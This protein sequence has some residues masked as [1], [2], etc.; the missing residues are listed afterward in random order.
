M[1]R[2]HARALARAAPHG[3]RP[4]HVRNRRQPRGGNARR[5]E[6][7]AHLDRTFMLS[8][9]A[10]AV[11]G[12]LLTGFTGAGTRGSAPLSVPHDCGCA[13]RRNVAGGSARRYWRTVLGALI[14]TLITTVLVGH[15]GRRGHAGDPLRRVDPRVRRRV[16]TRRARPR[17]RVAGGGRRP[18]RSRDGSQLSLLR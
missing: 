7:R 3:D 12:M 8:A 15:G 16:R 1:D 17:P 14:L 9:V 5:S 4:P 11:V 18:P 2:Y 10:A 6:D 13:R